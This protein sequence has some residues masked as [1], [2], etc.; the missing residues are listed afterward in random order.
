MNKPDTDK[1]KRIVVEGADDLSTI[2]NLWQ[3]LI[4][5][6]RVPHIEQCGGIKKLESTFDTQISS[7]ETQKIGIVVDAD[8]SADGR[9]ESI[10]RILDKLEVKFTVAPPKQMPPEGFVS[11]VKIEGK[12]VDRLG[13]W[14]MPDNVRPGAI[15]DFLLEMLPEQ[16]DL[17]QDVE[18]A[19]TRIEVTG[20]AR[21]KPEL[22]HNKAFVSTWLAW[23]EKP[24]MLYGDAVKKE[25][26]LNKD[27]TTCIGFVAW[28][29][30]LFLD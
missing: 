21:Y 8:V 25:A 24:R 23:Q 5:D 22:L 1:S 27:G 2:S 29:K 19:L 14:I 26:L 17:R 7:N 12:K 9:Y 4:P 13:I 11:S 10:L 30:K 3:S 18:D 28:L 6:H 16:D 15:E 20:K